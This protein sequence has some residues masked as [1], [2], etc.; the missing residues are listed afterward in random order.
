MKYVLYE[1]FLLQDPNF[2]LPFFSLVVLRCI[3][4]SYTTDDDDGH[5]CYISQT[6]YLMA[7]D[8]AFLQPKQ[9]QSDCDSNSGRLCTSVALNYFAGKAGRRSTGDGVPSPLDD[10][11]A[12][13]APDALSC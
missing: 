12:T 1:F 11:W 4:S 3:V 13:E 6:L 10:P 5:C 2:F 8:R 7:K 9:Q